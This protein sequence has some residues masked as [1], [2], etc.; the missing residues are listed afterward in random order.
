MKDIQYDQ[1]SLPMDEDPQEEI[2]YGPTEVMPQHDWEMY[3]STDLENMWSRM[4]DYLHMSGAAAYMMEFADYQTF[5]D[6]CYSN[7]K[8]LIYASNNVA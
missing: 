3:Y 7:S 8:G 5:V 1:Q 6:Y 4:K 2:I